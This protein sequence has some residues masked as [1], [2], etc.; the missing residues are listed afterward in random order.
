M[1]E[2]T[3]DEPVC[4]APGAPPPEPPSSDSSV[5][6][7]PEV[8][9]TCIACPR[10]MSKKTADHHTLCVSCRGFDCD[11]D[12]HCEECMEWPEEEV[13]LYA[14]YRKSLKFKTSLKPKSSAAPPPPPPANSVPS[15]QPSPR[16]DIQSQVDS[17]NVTVTNLAEI[18]T[19]R[20]DALTASL[21]SPPE[22]QS[23]SQPRLGPD[24]GEPQPGVTVATRR[25]FQALGVPNGTSAVPP[26]ASHP[27]GQGVRA[28]A[29]EQLGSASTPQ[30]QAAPGAAPPPSAASAP[31]P[32]PPRFKVPPSQ[33]STSGWVPSGPPPS[34]SAHDSRTSSES[35]ASD[36]ESD[37]SVRDSASSRLADLIYEVCPDSR[38]VL[39]TARPLRCGFEA[40]FGQPEST[41]SRQ[42]F[43]LYPRVAEVESEVAAR[44]EALARRAKPLSHIMPSR[45]R[46]YA[47]ADD[48]LFASSLPVNPSFAQLAGTRAVGSK[49]WGSISFAE[50]ERMERLF[51][52]QLEMTSSSLWLM[53]GILA[54]LKRD[55]FQPS[56]PTLFNAALSSV[57]ASL[58]QQA[59]STS[60]GSSFVRAKC[61]ESLLSH[62]TIPV[63][64]AQRRLLTT[65]P[66]S[67]EGLFDEGLLS[68][69]V[70][71]VQ[72]SSLISSNL[73]V[74]RSFGRAKSR[75]SSS[76]PLVNPSSWGPVVREALCLLLAI[77]RR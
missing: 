42:R 19:A 7:P 66:G 38:P 70:A 44:S 12:T 15:S 49:R 48:P 33:P 62:T 68:D 11:V 56:D 23:S 27:L 32:P 9:R 4:K 65:A 35:E 5:E 25:M 41:A 43:R 39:D 18:L 69:V 58:L 75:A 2:C 53:S 71:Q 24:V 16:G 61:R 10:R 20:L 52:T 47:V 14:K 30:P 60:A 57:S 8:C 6:T 72:R 37:V 1:S 67:C 21:L 73:A 51:R 46:H 74:S 76:S 36:T 13:K 28:P 29:V 59:R 17:L 55:G 22:T 64:E 63:P 40:W 54:M 34:R 50:M 77:R 26:T 45:S 31:P 3:L